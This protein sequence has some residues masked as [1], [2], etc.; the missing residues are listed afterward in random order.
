MASTKTKFTDKGL[1]A[2]ESG[3]WSNDTAHTGAGQFQARGMGNGKAQFYFRYSA[4]SDG[5][6][7]QVRVPIGVFPTLSLADGRKRA[8]ELSERYM[9]GERD[10]KTAL[11]A[12]EREKQRQAEARKAAEEAQAAKAAAS[13][14][15]LLT[16][17][18]DH[19]EASKKP[20][21]RLVRGTLT[22]HVRDVWPDLWMK[23]AAD[24][25]LDDLLPVIRRLSTDGK[26]REAAKLRSYLIS[27]FT[28]AIHARQS[29]D[30]G[31]VIESLAALKISSNPAKDIAPLKGASK[32]RKVAM[33]TEELRAY[34]NRIA[35]LDSVGGAALRFHLLSG[36]QRIEQLARIK[37]SDFDKD[38]VGVHMTDPKGRRADPRKHFVPLIPAAKAAMDAM[39]G[40][41]GP[42]LFSLT[43]GASHVTYESLRDHF[44]EIRTAML[45]AGELSPD[46]ANFS[47]GLIRATVETN[48]S[49]EGISKEHLAQLLSHGVSGVQSASYNHHD[50]A[51]EKR[52][53]LEVLH[54]IVSGHGDNVTPIR[55]KR[56]A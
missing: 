33:T 5:K 48:L 23:P 51:D 10:L 50:F 4:P 9:K 6:Q 49:R 28:A 8:R 25:V 54:R 55:R 39:G 15:T 2:L 7:A 30:G 56:S 19:L 42:H 46:K 26:K 35:A 11:D 27:A 36:G 21:A 47:V 40:D 24:V 1:K 37:K 17:Y 13:L 31:E 22:R 16:A 34:W 3:Q 53:A 45:Q 52:R 41:L 43:G 18:A 14:G 29:V 12:E 38:D 44:V 20:S 32:P